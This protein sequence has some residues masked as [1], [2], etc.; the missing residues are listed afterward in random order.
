M[1]AG[2]VVVTVSWLTVIASC[3]DRY[4]TELV[5]GC[6]ASTVLK[7]L[8]ASKQMHPMHS[9]DG[10]VCAAEL[11]SPEQHTARDHARSRC[12]RQSPAHVRWVRRLMLLAV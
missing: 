6:Y 3:A 11:S 2:Y 4:M 5:S 1:H 12:L 8:Q 10:F 7:S 9:S